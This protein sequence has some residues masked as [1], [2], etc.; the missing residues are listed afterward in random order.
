MTDLDLQKIFHKLFTSQHSSNNKS[1]HQDPNKGITANS[2]F[3]NEKFTHPPQKITVKSIDDSVFKYDTPLDKQILEASGINPKLFNPSWLKPGLEFEPQL[4]EL[5]ERRITDASGDSSLAE[6]FEDGALKINLDPNKYRHLNQIDIDRFGRR[7]SQPM[8]LVDVTVT[9][10]DME[11]GSVIN[12][13]TE[14]VDPIRGTALVNLKDKLDAISTWS[15]RDR[16]AIH[17][18]TSVSSGSTKH[19]FESFE[20]PITLIKPLRWGSQHVGDETGN[21][22]IYQEVAPAAGSGRIYRGRGGTDFLHLENINSGDVVSFNGRAGIDPAEAADLG[23]QAFYGGTVFDSLTLSN[24]DELYLQGI[25]RLRFS[26]A[27]ID[28]TPN[29]DATSEL[30]WNTNVMDVPGAWRFNTGSNDVVLVSLDSGLRDDGSG[31]PAF[32]AE[33][34]H[35]DY[36][37]EVNSYNS[38]HGHRSMSLMAARHD[39][40]GVAGIAPDS[41]L[42]SFNAKTANQNGIGFE[43]ALEQT[44][45]RREGHQRIVFQGGVQGDWPW[46]SD[47][48]STREEV[49]AEFAASRP[50]GFFA[51]A[52]GNGGGQTFSENDYLTTV[53]GV[54]EAAVSYDNITSVGAL[55]SGL[56]TD[57][58]GL[59]NATDVSL[60]TYSNRGSNLTLVAPTDSWAMDV[61]GTRSWF[62]GT[63]ASNPNLAG[64]AALV[65]SE[66]N[67]LTGG[68]LREILISSAMDLGTGGVDTTFGNGL[69]NAESAI[70]RA[71]AL[72]ANQE[73]ALF[74]D[75]NS[76]LA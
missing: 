32:N 37:T 43:A 53:S 74:W 54:A 64:V 38:E 46:T 71:H 75:N 25:E 31:S 11:T 15:L 58:D 59:I 57:I 40:T 35:V 63:S 55:E 29:L 45:E 47:G 39:G 65:W 44:R 36:L 66:N 69:A 76:F 50:W 67:D 14:V 18:E 62:D 12:L 52:A 73:L 60:A 6:V 4:P 13:G 42:W 21:D 27:T 30:Q 2:D 26:D 9:A 70:R 49:E 51:I 1:P 10:T 23:R 5:K 20:E 8:S 7:H 56:R 41:Q 22:L 17:V 48:A 28:L 33:I 34:D 16:Y 68:Q 3:E 61:D 24:G 72:E 19:V